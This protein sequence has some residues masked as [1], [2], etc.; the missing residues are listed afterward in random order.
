MTAASKQLRYWLASTHLLPMRTTKFL[1]WL[2]HV[3]DLPSLFGA[4]AKQLNQ[5]AFTAAEITKIK[6]VNWATIALE[7]QWYAKHGTIITINDSLY[8]QLLQE[9]AEPPLVLYV[10]GNPALLAQPQLAIIGSH[11]PSATGYSTAKNFAQELAKTGLVITSGLGLG[12]D[13]A[14]HYGALAMGK[15]IAVLGHGLK[16]IYPAVNNQLAQAISR[17]GALVS[18][19][20]LTSDPLAWHFP[21]RNRIISGL[22]IGI[23]VVEATVGSGALT[24]A[25]HAL[26]QN[27]EIFAIPG[28]I[29]QPLAR[30]CHHLI[31]Q[32]AKLVECT[33]DIL[34][35]LSPLLNR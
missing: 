28:S 12:I 29:Q 25:K 13:T 8:P 2:Q 27:R 32:G 9:I 22:S 11:H 3:G 1:H 33:Q 21:Y 6:R 23:L 20:P 17:N 10:C 15:T 24:I 35:E 18:S 19:F 31:R 30:G 26:E 16:T 4:T 5:A 7:Q 34:T 14:G